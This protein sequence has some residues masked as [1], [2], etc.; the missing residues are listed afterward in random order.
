M[1]IFVGNHYVVGT[2]RDDFSISAKRM[3]FPIYR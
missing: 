2:F 1:N 3:L